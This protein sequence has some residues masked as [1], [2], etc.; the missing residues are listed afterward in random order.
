MSAEKTTATAFGVATSTFPVADAR[1]KKVRFNGHIKT[2]KVSDGFAGL[3]W[4][5]DGK[6]MKVL[7]FDPY[8]SH[9][10]APDGDFRYAPLPDVLAQADIISL[11]CPPLP[12]GGGDRPLRVSFR[13][14]PGKGMSDDLFA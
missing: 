5:V 13:T 3:W 8:P 4:R 1:G 6:S 9:G 14:A 11:H 12:D 7:A 2:E 10:F